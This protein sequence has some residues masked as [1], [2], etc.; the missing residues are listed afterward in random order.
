MAECSVWEQSNVET[1]KV[2]M[3]TW[4]LNILAFLVM[5]TTAMVCCIAMHSTLYACSAIEHV[6]LLNEQHAKCSSHRPIRQVWWAP[7]GTADC[8]KEAWRQSFPYMQF[9]KKSMQVGDELRA[10]ASCWYLLRKHRPT[11]AMLLSHT[12]QPIY[13]QH[14][15]ILILPSWV[16]LVYGATRQHAS[17][18]KDMRTCC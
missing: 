15:I 2:S 13:L 11:Y 3:Q 17:A 6:I 1:H 16:Q 4:G 14:Q 12:S 8:C 10:K 7:S 5:T 9:Q 18:Y